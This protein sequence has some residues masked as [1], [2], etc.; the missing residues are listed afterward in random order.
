VK[1]GLPILLLLSITGPVFGQT[2]QVEGGASSLYQASGASV[3]LYE[4]RFTSTVGMGIDQGRLVGS[5]ATQFDFKGWTVNAGDKQIFFSSGAAGIGIASRG[6]LVSRKSKNSEVAFFVGAVGRAS[7]TPFFTGTQALHFGTGFTYKHAFTRGFAFGTV[8]AAAGNLHTSTEELSYKWRALSL[9]E[10][11]GLLENKA[12]ANGQAQIQFR[13]FGGAVSRTNYVFQNQNAAV[14]NEGFAALF[15]PI[16]L[17]ASAFQSN[18]T[19]GETLG[20]GAR[21]GFVSIRGDQFWSRQGRT[22]AGSISEHLGRF[23]L[24]QY[25]NRS[26]G[27]T[28]FSAGGQFQSNWLSASLDHTMLYSIFTGSFQQTTVVTLSFRVHDAAVNLGTVNGK[29]TAYGSQYIQTGLAISG[30]LQHSVRSGKYLISGTVV[31]EHGDPV[32]GAA[33]VI[34]REVVYTDSQG[35][36]AL[37]TTKSKPLSIHLDPPE[38][39]AP[40][41]WIPADCPETA[42]PGAPITVKARRQPS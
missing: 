34:G 36:F 17:H 39:A 8:A 37:R 3:V 19:T 10:T 40:G 35:R 41:K 2:L 16:D 20:A 12:F 7:T 42:T 24:S 31:D 26:N 11:A 1:L 21:F 15:G 28:T 14:T 25:V 27:Q 4:P 18:H 38:F 32:E 6:F 33:L 13:H 22:F 23:R 29:W 30:E 5:A 9:S